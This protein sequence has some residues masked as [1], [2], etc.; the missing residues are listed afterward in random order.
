M[1]RR[2]GALGASSRSAMPVAALTDLATWAGGRSL[3]QGLFRGWPGTGAG[4]QPR[5]R[6]FYSTMM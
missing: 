2:V 4:A 1:R 5:I 3:T 6:A